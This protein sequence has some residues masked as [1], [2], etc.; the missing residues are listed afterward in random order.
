MALRARA[1]R[2]RRR[3]SRCRRRSR[4]CCAPA[5]STKLAHSAWLRSVAP[6]ADQC[7]VGSAC[8][9]SPSP[10]STAASQ[11]TASAA[12][13]G[14]ARLQ[15]RVVA[16]R[17]DDARAEALP[18][19][20]DRLAVHVVV[21]V[22]RDEHRVDP[23]QVVEGDAR[24]VDALGADE[25]E[26][27]GALGPHRIDQHVAPPRLDQ[28]A[29]RARRR[30]RAPRRRRRA[31]AAGRRRT[32][33]G[34]SAGHAAPRS[35]SCQRSKASAPLRP[36]LAR[37]E[38]PH[39]VEMV[40][41]RTLVVGVGAPAARAAPSRRRRPRRPHRASVSTRRRLGIIPPRYAVATAAAL[42]RARFAARRAQV[43]TMPLFPVNVCSRMLQPER[44]ERE[45]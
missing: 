14:T 15:D 22:V 43:S 9:T 19:P 28:E 26:R 21:V 7:S 16:E 32:G 39:A 2:W 1:R 5:C 24:R 36:G 37:V 8:T 18:Q 29:T 45:Q 33:S 12:R 44:E 11:S 34:S 41:H 35:A 38:E 23:R 17:R 13:P 31:R 3:R 6:R 42:R 30:R 25:G 4:P 10:R 40:R 20:A 27:A